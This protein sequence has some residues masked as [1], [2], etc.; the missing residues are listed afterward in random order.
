MTFFRIDWFD[1]LAVQGTVKNL[2]QDH[3]SKASI[4]QH[5]VFYGPTLTSVSVHDYW[6]N[7]SFDYMDFFGKVMSLL[8][9]TLSRFVIAFFPG[10]SKLQSLSAVILDPKK[11][12]SITVFHL[13][14]SDR[15]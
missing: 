13:P 11:I 9:N 12:K 1:L 6:K 3:S 2:L 15:T 7:H 5:S 4:F 8:F 10:T 14:W